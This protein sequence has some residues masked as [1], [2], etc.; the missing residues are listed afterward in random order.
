MRVAVTG[1]SGLIGKELVRS[2][3]ADDHD[4]V[5]VVRSTPDGPGEVGWDPDAG[6]LDAGGLRG[7]DAV[8]HLAGEPI[9]GFW[10]AS[11]KDA[12][13]DSRV[14]GTTLLAEALAELAAADD[15]PSV[16]VSSSAVG[17]YG[18][19]RG[20]EVLTEESASGGGFLAEVCRQWEA[21]T[22]P[23][24]QAGVRVVHL[25]TGVVQSADGGQLG[26]QLP[27]FKLGLGGKLG[28]GQQWLSWITLPDIVGLYRFALDDD[29]LR[30]ALN[31]T[32]PEPVRNETYTRTLARVVARPAFFAVPKF[33]P[34][35][36]LGP[37]GAR[38]VALA[39]QRV[40]PGVA[41]DRGYVFRHP[42]LERGLRDVLGR[43]EPLA[44]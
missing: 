39:D 41:L 43:P 36:L 21:A 26:L 31:G 10:T 19:D 44:A 4:V 42:G 7:C 20:D 17:F 1:S 14:K 22:R 33:A 25:R 32:A 9:N 13:L 28:S 12:I 11:K 18:N 8:V 34:A 2:L 6:R 38:E 15:G 5:R 35:F 16:L 40:Q 30:G 3:R 29:E 24:E 27:L 37:D 23:A